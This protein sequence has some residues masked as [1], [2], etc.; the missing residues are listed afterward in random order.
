MESAC[1]GTA[2]RIIFFGAGLA[3][4]YRVWYGF[5]DNGTVTGECHVM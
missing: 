3:E 4:L 1:R 5:I 2:P